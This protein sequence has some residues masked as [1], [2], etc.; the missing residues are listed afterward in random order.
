MI[1]KN[2]LKIFNFGKVDLKNS[3]VFLNDFIAEIVDHSF[4]KVEHFLSEQI[5]FFEIVDIC[6][7][8]GLQVEP[9]TVELPFN[10][11]A[12]KQISKKCLVFA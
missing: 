1:I 5:S 6:Y 9:N 12:P 4:D 2:I 10:E 8:S 3:P 7:F 11:F